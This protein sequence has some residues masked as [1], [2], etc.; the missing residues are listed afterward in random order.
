LFYCTPIR[1]LE[2]R[3]SPVLGCRRRLAGDQRHGIDG[4][5]ELGSSVCGEIG[6][7]MQGGCAGE[8]VP[9]SDPVAGAQDLD[10][11]QHGDHSARGGELEG[12]LQKSDGKVWPVPVSSTSRSPPSVT[13][14]QA[15]AHLCWDLLGPEPGRIPDYKVETT[16]RKHVR[17]VNLVVKPGDLSLAAESTTRMPDGLKR[18]SEGTQL[19]PQFPVESAPLPKQV[20]SPALMQAIDDLR[21]CPL[22]GH[23][24]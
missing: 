24:Q 6:Y 7:R 1:E 21:P 22:L 3:A 2:R 19:G 12:S 18:P 15:V 20:A 11:D 10:G 5:L 23:S 13:S 9:G 8:G 16:A 17:E 4:C 14:G